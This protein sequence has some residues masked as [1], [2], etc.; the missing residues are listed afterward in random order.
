MIAWK[1]A[2]SQD[3]FQGRPGVPDS[4]PDADL[5]S[6]E[7]GRGNVRTTG[8][9]SGRSTSRR[10][11]SCRVRADTAARCTSRAVRTGVPSASS[12]WSPGR[13]PARAAVLSGVTASTA[14][15]S[16]SAS[17]R[18]V[19]PRRARGGAGAGRAGGA[20]VQSAAGGCGAHLRGAYGAGRTIPCAGPSKC[21][22]CLV[23]ETCRHLGG[24][25]SAPDRGGKLIWAS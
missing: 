14:I 6:D 17:G 22:H 7:R 8:P 18:R 1:Q 25:L 20:P 24:L 19:K 23:S 11:S 13:N 15:P 2:S 4:A 16:A 3:I 9:P 10:R 21:G 12:R 5:P